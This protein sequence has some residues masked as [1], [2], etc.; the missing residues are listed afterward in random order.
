MFYKWQRWF[1]YGNY[2]D[3]VRLTN[4]ATS[5]TAYKY[6]VHDHLYSP[7]DLAELLA[8]HRDTLQ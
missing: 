4:T 5:L 6:Y 3:E 8:D 7:G 1:A 2:I